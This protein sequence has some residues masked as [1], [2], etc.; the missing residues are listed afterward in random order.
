LRYKFGWLFLVVILFLYLILPVF[1]ETTYVTYGAVNV[2]IFVIALP[3]VDAHGVGNVTKAVEGV[4]E[5]VN[6]CLHKDSAILWPIH[7]WVGCDEKV[8]GRI[9]LTVS[10]SLVSDWDFYRRIV[11]TGSNI[12][13]VNVHGE[14]ILV[15]SGYTKEAWI[16]K[17]AETMLHRNMTWVHTAGY[18]FYYYYSQH[19]EKGEWGEDGFK[20]LMEHIGKEN[21][22][23]QPPDSE[24]TKVFLS[25]ATEYTIGHTWS[26]VF[27]ASFAERGK[28]LNFS[29]LK[30]CGFS[31]IWGQV[32]YLT[33]AVIRFF[34]PGS[35]GG[36]GFYI[37]IGTYKTFSSSSKESDGDFLR[38][39]IG[40]AEAIYTTAFNEIAWQLIQK[41]ENALKEAENEGRTIGLDKTRYNITA[42]QLLQEAKVAYYYRLGG[43]TVIEYAEEVIR[44]AEMAKKPN[45]IDVYAKHLT[46][47]SITG[48]AFAFLLI[49]SVKNSR[50]K[51]DE[52]G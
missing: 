9:S 17:I 24:D 36:S 12:I 48:V 39:Y 51:I 7:F 11:E 31:I 19:G 32:P 13:I 34:K 16:D 40:T 18:P 15:P 43:P 50:R 47:L 22:R 30:D 45:F 25:G 27:Q 33:G 6:E 35:M 1:A 44:V 28:P 42:K 26:Y 3:G 10:C 41:A 21:V 38:S 49:K 4:F 8:F 52:K 2:R 29:D 23:C 5:A 37:H 46:I 14:T 20:R